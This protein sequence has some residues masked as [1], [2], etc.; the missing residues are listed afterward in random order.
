MEGKMLMSSVEKE[1]IDIEEAKVLLQL[2][3]VNNKI[4]VNFNLT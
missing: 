4:S 1:V 3:N 2:T